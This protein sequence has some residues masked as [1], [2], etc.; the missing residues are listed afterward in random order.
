MALNV[1]ISIR[2]L[3]NSSIRIEFNATIESSGDEFD[4][5]KNFKSVLNSMDIKK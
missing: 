2:S 3:T 1:A 5:N 4:L